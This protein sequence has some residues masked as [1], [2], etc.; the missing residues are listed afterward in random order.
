MRIHVTVVNLHGVLVGVVRIDHLC[1]DLVAVVLT[2][3]ILGAIRVTHRS[4][5]SKRHGRKCRR[6][7]LLEAAQVAFLILPILNTRLSMA[8]KTCTTRPTVIDEVQIQLIIAT[9]RT[10]RG[11]AE[12]LPTHKSDY[13][14]TNGSHASDFVVTIFLRA[15]GLLR[16][17]TVLNFYIPRTVTKT[18]RFHNERINNIGIGVMFRNNF[19]SI[20]RVISCILVVIYIYIMKDFHSLTFAEG[21][22]AVGGWNRDWDWTGR[23]GTER[24]GYDVLA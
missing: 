8:Q 20:C 21:F 23:D 6:E 2:T 14:F 3:H 9:F 12:K 17:T 5:L 11:T 19:P 24:D 15:L 16:F 13:T 7:T 10:H 18:I 22:W 1:Q 4:P